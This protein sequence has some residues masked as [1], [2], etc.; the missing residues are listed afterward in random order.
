MDLGFRF[1]VVES[2]LRSVNTKIQSG[3]TDYSEIGSFIW[4]AK[5][6]AENF[7]SCHFN[8]SD[9]NGNQMAHAMTLVGKRRFDDRFWVEITLESPSL[10]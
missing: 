3:E 2:D 4:D 10:C 6:L 1:V 8:F 9:P 5:L 7:I